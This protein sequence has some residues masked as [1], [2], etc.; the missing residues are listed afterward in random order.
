MTASTHGVS[1]AAALPW[2]EPRPIETLVEP[3][4]GA[5]APEGMHCSDSILVYNP[6][7]GWHLLW[8]MMAD[9]IQEI[10]TCGCY[11]HWMPGPPEPA[12]FDR[13]EWLRRSQ[14]HAA[15]GEQAV[16]G[17]VTA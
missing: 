15:A 7:D 3:D 9:P 6:C 17:A 11:T 1:L 4:E 16:A 8:L 13:E 14:M 2:H 10:R 5:L 12:N